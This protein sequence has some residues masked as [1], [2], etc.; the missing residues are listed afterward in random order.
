MTS[1]KLGGSNDKVLSSQEIR[2]IAGPIA[3]HSVIAILKTGA[4]VTDLE[5]AVIHVRGEGEYD[6]TGHTLSGKAA[7]ISDILSKDELYTSDEER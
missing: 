2:R 7:L 4:S 6:V 3:D 1:S 5:V